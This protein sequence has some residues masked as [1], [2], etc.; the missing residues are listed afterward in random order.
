MLSLVILSLLFLHVCIW[1]TR[2]ITETHFQQLHPSFKAWIILPKS[3]PIGDKKIN[4]RLLISPP[5]TAIKVTAWWLLHFPTHVPADGVTGPCSSV[6][7]NISHSLLSV[8]YLFRLLHFILLPFTS[9]SFSL[10][11][12]MPPTSLS[13]YFLSPTRSRKQF[14]CQAKSSVCDSL[15]WWCMCEDARQ[16][17]LD[18][19]TF[20]DTHGA[21]YLNGSS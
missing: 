2:T 3:P 4:C 5:L 14:T 21:G 11:T 8:I 17:E 15:L 12:S 16:H 7:K 20:S 9:H 6:Q 19:N 10:T 1:V 13:P 18:R